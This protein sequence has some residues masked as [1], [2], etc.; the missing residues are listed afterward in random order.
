M[1]WIVKTPAPLGT[2]T[3]LAN[4]TKFLYA[5]IAHVP[6]FGKQYSSVYFPRILLHSSQWD[7]F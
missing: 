2:T 4:E 6:I 1:Q 7:K 3:L 5:A